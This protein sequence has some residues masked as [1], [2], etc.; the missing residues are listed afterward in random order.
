MTPDDADLPLFLRLS[1]GLF[2]P[3][4]LSVALFLSCV[5]SSVKLRLRLYLR[6][7]SRV[8]TELFAGFRP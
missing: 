4:C 6:D 1:Q 7:W 5:L 2:F 8:F 3:S